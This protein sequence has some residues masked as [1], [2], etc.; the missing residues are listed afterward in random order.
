MGRIGSTGDD[1][2]SVGRARRGS[3][4]G[5]GK[6]VW[7]AGMANDLAHF[8]APPMARQ[9][10]HGHFCGDCLRRAVSRPDDDGSRIDLR[11]ATALCGRPSGQGRT[12]RASD[13]DL[14]LLLVRLRSEWD[15][16]HGDLGY[17][18]DSRD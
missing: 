2:P 11:I 5:G 1:L 7:D 10:T 3:F 4:A 6:N 12:H 17:A 8:G 14:L 18:G 9:T 16:T 13:P 15:G